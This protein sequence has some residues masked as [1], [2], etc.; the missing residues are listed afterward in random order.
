MS[1]DD[2]KDKLIQA[3][4]KILG[5]GIMDHINAVVDDG[6][7]KDLDEDMKAAMVLYAIDNV[8]VS[9]IA[10]TSVQH[11]EEGDRGKFCIETVESHTRN[12]QGGIMKFI[13]TKLGDDPLTK[14]ADQIGAIVEE[15]MKTDEDDDTVH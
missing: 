13:T 4:A 2:T 14:L 10:Q 9:V 8:V 12:V 3:N 11:I 15:T 5:A 7:F 6:E 1:D